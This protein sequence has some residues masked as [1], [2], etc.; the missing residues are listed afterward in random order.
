MRQ[1]GLR[2]GGERV[3]GGEAERVAERWGEYREGR[4]GRR[5]EEEV[6][7]SDITHQYVCHLQ[8]KNIS[9][10]PKPLL[11]P[12]PQTFSPVRRASTTLCTRAQQPG[13]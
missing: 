7:V 3:G 4:E 13:A 2:R 6:A 11:P 10:F 1:R 5:E 12:P 8:I 9:S